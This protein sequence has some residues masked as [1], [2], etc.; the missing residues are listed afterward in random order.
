MTAH[1]ASNVHTISHRGATVTMTDK[2]YDE[3]LAMAN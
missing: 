3:L 1:D 2:I